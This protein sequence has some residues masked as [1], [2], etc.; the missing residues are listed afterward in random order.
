MERNNLTRRELLRF[1]AL[2]LAAFPLATVASGFAQQKTFVEP[3]DLAYGGTDEKFLD[4]IQ[5]ASFNFFWEIID[6]FWDF[7]LFMC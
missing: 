4:E 1:S 6:F 7:K 3:T 2:G 5:R